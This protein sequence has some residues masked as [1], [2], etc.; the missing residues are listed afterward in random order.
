MLEILARKETA[1]AKGEATKKLNRVR[2]Q[3]DRKGAVEKTKL[4]T[5]ASRSLLTYF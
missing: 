5:Y 4:Q 2:D 3:L 1:R